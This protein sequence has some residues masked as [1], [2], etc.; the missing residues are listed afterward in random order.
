LCL[1]YFCFVVAAFVCVFMTYSTSCCCHYKHMDPGYVC[2][3]AWVWN[4]V[5]HPKNIVWGC[6]RTYCRWGGGAS[7]AML[8][9]ISWWGA[10]WFVGLHF[11]A[12]S[13]DDKLEVE[14]GGVGSTHEGDELI[15]LQHF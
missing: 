4:L 11:S 3:Y 14:V 15:G 6:L 12:S 8:E 13:L 7:N 5:C 1:F 2:M 9:K 10:S